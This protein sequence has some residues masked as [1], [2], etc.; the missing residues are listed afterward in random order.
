M[1][2][3]PPPRR[4]FAPPSTALTVVPKRD[5]K[6]REVALQRKADL[7]IPDEIWLMLQDCGEKAAEHLYRLLHDPIF[8]KRKLHEQI[9]IIE[10]AMLRS[11]GAPEGS[12]KRDMPPPKGEANAEQG[13][14]LTRLAQRAKF[15][16][17][18]AVAEKVNA[19]KDG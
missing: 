10:L 13:N 5:D 9:R 18:A 11:Y 1:S 4:G 15:P 2:N 19:R 12:F 3:L 16:E 14:A 6:G 17:L 8:E 7:R